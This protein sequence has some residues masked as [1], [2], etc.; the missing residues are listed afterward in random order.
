MTPTQREILNEAIEI[1]AKFP[2]DLRVW[3]EQTRIIRRV[4][5]E[6]KPET[7]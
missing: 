2:Q 6:I 3:Q 7:P 4:L 5:A 1:L